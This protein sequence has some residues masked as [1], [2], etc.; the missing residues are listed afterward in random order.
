MIYVIQFRFAKLEDTQLA[1]KFES[2]IPSS[3]FPLG[4]KTMYRAYANDTNFEIISDSDSTN[5]LGVKAARVHCSWQPQ[6]ANYNNNKEGMYILQSFPR[7]PIEPDQFI[8]GS[9]KDA[10]KTYNEFVELFP[11]KLDAQKEWQEFLSMAPKSDDAWEYVQENDNVFYIPL[12]SILFGSL[13]TSSYSQPVR[14]TV[15]TCINHRAP[16][17]HDIFRPSMQEG[18][19]DHNLENITAAPSVQWGG[20]GNYVPVFP[21]RVSN[22]TGLSV[23]QLRL[24]QAWN[25]QDY[26][27]LTSKQLADLC[28]A[29]GLATTAPRKSKFV[30]R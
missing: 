28:K 29:R 5:V 24:D 8:E 23:E 3:E 19:P 17:S 9:R 22:I 2:V 6:A 14:I 21:N 4:V 26:N 20:R 30:E 27:V 15:N 25:V 10:E 13:V 7:G 12:K 1:W 18:L 16:N 11:G